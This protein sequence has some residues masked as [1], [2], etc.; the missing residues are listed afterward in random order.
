MHRLRTSTIKHHISHLRQ[1]LK[2]STN[3]ILEKTKH[4]RIHLDLVRR[5]NHNTP[6]RRRTRIN[7]SHLPQEHP[8]DMDLHQAVIGSLGQEGLRHTIRKKAM[9]QDILEGELMTVRL[10][11]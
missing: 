3:R 2:D 11:F 9:G 6:Q 4:H 8:L 5:V 7:T 10:S 1:I